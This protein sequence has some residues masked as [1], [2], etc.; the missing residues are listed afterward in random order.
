MQSTKTSTVSSNSPSCRRAT[1]KLLDTALTCM[2]GSIILRRLAI[3]A[4]FFNPSECKPNVCRVKLPISSA[5]SSIK[6]KS[7]T[8]ILANN[9]ARQEPIAP[10][11][12]I[13]N[14]NLRVIEDNAPRLSTS[15]SSQHLESNHSISTSSVVIFF[16]RS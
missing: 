16:I 14:F 3:S 1:S 15:L 7:F 6:R 5:S 11:P 10:N 9:S 4:D 13:A 8:P 2:D 12:I